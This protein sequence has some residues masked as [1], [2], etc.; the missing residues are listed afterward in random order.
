VQ[1]FKPA[2]ALVAATRAARLTLSIVFTGGEYTWRCQLVN[3]LIC[4]A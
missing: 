3:A 2:V 4:H 1:A